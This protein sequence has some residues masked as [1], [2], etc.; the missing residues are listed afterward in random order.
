VSQINFASINENFPVAGQDNDTQ[1][2]RDNFDTIKTNFRLAQEEISDLENNTARTDQET[3][4]NNNIVSTA[5][6]RNNRD[7]ILDGGAI[8]VNQLGVDYANGNYQIFRIGADVT[9]GLLGLPTD[10]S[11]PRGVGKVTLEL[12]SDGA[13]R[14]VTLDPSNAVTYKKKSSDSTFTWSSNIFTV[15]SSSNPVIIEI[16]RHSSETVF[17]NYLGTFA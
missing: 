12:Y 10:T 1:V 16:W 2:F 7:I 15:S 9:L 4:F 13:A 11:F 6:F 5:V 3:E 14:T 17:V 8:S